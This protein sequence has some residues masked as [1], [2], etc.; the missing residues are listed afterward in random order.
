MPRM[1]RRR[2]GQQ[3]K[4]APAAVRDKMAARR[5]IG[6]SH[7]D[8]SGLPVNV[9]VIGSKRTQS[10]HTEVHSTP[11]LPKMQQPMRAF[12]EERITKLWYPCREYYMGIRRETGNERRF[13]L[14]LR[15]RRLPTTLR[16]WTKPSTGTSMWLLF[17]EVPRVIN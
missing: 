9:H 8:W 16:K 15:H 7:D 5:I 11:Q 13:W 6:L 2:S 17:W 10:W 12:K 14:M 1:W 3:H 4:T